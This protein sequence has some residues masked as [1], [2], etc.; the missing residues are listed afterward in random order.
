MSAG[1]A[2]RRAKRPWSACK[3]QVGHRVRIVKGALS[4]LSG[5]IVKNYGSG[6]WLLT[7]DGLGDKLYVILADDWLELDPGSIEG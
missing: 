7:L 1:D 2:F 4:G 6:R 5:R 3:L